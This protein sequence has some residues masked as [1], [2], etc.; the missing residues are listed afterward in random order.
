MKVRIT[1]EAER[2]LDDIAEFIA[3]DN[4]QRALPFI[5]ELRDKCLNLAAAPLAFALLPRYEGLGVRRRV[6]GNY[7]IF[8]RVDGKEVIALH[9]LHG[10]MDFAEILFDP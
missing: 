5:L 8:S 7:L 9:V 2:D 3:R 1:A 10:A 4:P 6:D